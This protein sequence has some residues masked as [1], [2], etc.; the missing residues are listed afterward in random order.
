MGSFTLTILL[1]ILV[2]AV[3]LLNIATSEVVVIKIRDRVKI[4]R[5]H[6]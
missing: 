4:Q 6:H 5:G 3:V 1:S 2:L